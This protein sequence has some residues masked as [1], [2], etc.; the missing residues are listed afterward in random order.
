MSWSSL[1]SFQGSRYSV[2]YQLCEEV[3]FVRR[4]GDE[5]VITATDLN[6]AKEVARHQVAGKGQITLVDEHYPERPSG[7][8]AGSEGRNHLRGELPGHR[9][10][11]QALPGRDG[12]HR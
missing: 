9:R 11:G 5:V 8:G 3:V 1:I 10:G 4:D 7:P 6:G 12:R 2:P